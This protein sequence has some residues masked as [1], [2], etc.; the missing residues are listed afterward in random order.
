MTLDPPAN[1]RGFVEA[2]LAS[3]AYTSEAELIEAALRQMSEQVPTEAGGEG[4]AGDRA[5]D[6]Y[7]LWGAVPRRPR[8]RGRG[9]PDR[10][11]RSSESDR[12]GR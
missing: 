5:I 4:G 6:R 3:G 9:D 10:T 12:A 7:P 2:Q 1:L 8:G 11:G